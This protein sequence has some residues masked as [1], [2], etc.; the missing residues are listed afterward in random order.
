MIFKFNS[1]RLQ[2]TASSRARRREHAPQLAHERVV[3]A[4]GAAF[5]VMETGGIQLEKNK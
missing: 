5:V 4:T 1:Y 3:V 2:L